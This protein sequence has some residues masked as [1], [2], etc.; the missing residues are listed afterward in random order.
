MSIAHLAPE[1]RAALELPDEQRIAFLAEDRWID[2]PRA[3]KAL[4][5]LERLLTCP[6][7]T[8]MPSFLIHGESNIGKSMIIQKFLR[9][10]PRREFNH[11]TGMLQLDVLVVE[12]PSGPTERRFYG[13]LLLAMNAPYRPSDRLAAVEFTALTLLRQVGPKMIVVDEVHNLLAGSAREQRASLN[14]L[15]F[16]SNQV[17][18]SIVALGTRDALAAV[19]TDPQIASRFPG[20]ELPRWQENEDLRGFLAGFERQLPLR[21]PSRLSDNRTI[22]NGI[23]SATGGVTGEITAL[24]SHAAEAAIRTKTECI[25]P[26]LLQ[27]AGGK[28]RFHP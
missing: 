22:V 12:M 7:R 2:Y 20:L 4:R 13:Q 5:E 8:R 11:D 28:V 15:K 19:Q 26:E 18:C 24:L 27:V 23:M 25:T 16:L 1:A 3:R 21:K 14:L 10:H 17:P 9:D 6:Q